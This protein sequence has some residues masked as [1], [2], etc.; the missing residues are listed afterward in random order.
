MTPGA[1]FENLFGGL[2]KAEYISVMETK[3]PTDRQI[4]IVGML[5]DGFRQTEIGAGIGISTRSVE[6]DLKKIRAAWGLKSLPQIVAHF[7]AKGWIN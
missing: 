4:K 5:A 1:S 6:S 7:I 3:K 2:R